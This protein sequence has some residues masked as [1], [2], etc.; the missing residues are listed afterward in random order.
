MPSV[1]SLL[2]IGHMLQGG[3]VEHDVRRER[4]D[5][6][7]HALAVA[8]VGDDAVD[9]GVALAERG[10]LDD[11]VQRRLGALEHEQVAGPEGDDAGAD[12]RCRS[13]RRR[14]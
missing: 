4:A 14:R 6:L 3:G 5:H 2:E 7:A 13:S 1:Q 12:L 9:A 8:H 10:R 11:C